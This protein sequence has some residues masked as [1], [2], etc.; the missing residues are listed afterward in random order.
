VSIG[1]RS[2][3]AQDEQALAGQLV[4]AKVHLFLRTSARLVFVGPKGPLD[5]SLTL[6]SITGEPLV[7]TD[8]T[9]ASM[10]EGQVLV[11]DTAG[12]TVPA[13]ASD[14]TDLYFRLMP[15]ATDK[16][17]VPADGA[18]R[19]LNLQRGLGKERLALLPTAVGATDDEAEADELDTAQVGGAES[20]KRRSIDSTFTAAAR[21]ALLQPLGYLADAYADALETHHAK[22]PN[23]A[24]AA[25]IGIQLRERKL[26]DEDIDLL[27]CLAHI[28]GRGYSGA[29][30]TL[31]EP[32]FYQ[33]VFVDEVQDFTEQQVYLMVEQARP[34]YRAITVVGD[35]AQKLH[36]GNAIDI[37]ACFPDD[38]VPNVQLT[39]NLRQ[40]DA[41]GLAWFSA[42]FRAELQ[43]RLA[44]I[45][46]SSMLADRMREHADQLRGPEL[47]FVDDDIELV[48]QVVEALGCL[49]ASQTAAVITPDS[50]TAAALYAQCKLQ[51]S[52]RM[53][54]AEL[55]EKIDLSRRH[56]RHFTS[57]ANSKGLEFDVVIVPY[58]ERYRLDDATDVNRLYVALT[59]PRRR[60]VLLSNAGRAESVFDQIWARYEGTLVVA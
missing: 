14:V 28:L 42:C 10:D 25:R 39:E 32:N 60:L 23:A 58:L 6:L 1:S 16:L 30:V 57:V 51:L 43:D 13:K 40:L 45:T 17:F 48:Q 2:W 8:T 15:E 55:S 31:T 54:D 12:K 53:V 38:A 26:A 18:L 29:T 9:R 22:F 19:R 35:I 59:R 37:R 7:W 46:P 56:V 49:K 52:A 24:L 20:Q 21:R 4:A 36:N 33:A 27:L 34:E 3:F 50:I 11:R 47:V 5:T 44:G 41:P